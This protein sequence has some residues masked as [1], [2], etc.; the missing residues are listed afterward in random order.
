[1]AGLPCVPTLTEIGWA[2]SIAHRFD[3]AFADFMSSDFSQS[4]EFQGTIA[5]LP[6]II[7]K[8]AGDLLECANLAKSQLTAHLTDLFEQVEVKTEV[9]VYEDND[10]KAMLIFNI[11]AVENGV[12]YSFTRAIE[13]IKSRTLN[14]LDINNG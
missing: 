13:D 8:T 11:T 2:T 7:Q 12:A 10:S 14:L 6:Y 9:R 1:M 4:E 3:F 5:S